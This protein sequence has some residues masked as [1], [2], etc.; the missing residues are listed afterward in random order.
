M[1]NADPPED[2]P[3]YGV[4]RLSKYKYFEA[5]TYGKDAICLIYVICVRGINIM[6]PTCSTAQYIVFLIARITYM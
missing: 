5:K 6:K 4:K 3:I 1:K 2:N